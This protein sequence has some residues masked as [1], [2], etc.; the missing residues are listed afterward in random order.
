MQ[1]VKFILCPARHEMGEFWE[2][3]NSVFPSTI[4]DPMDFHELERIASESLKGLQAGDE[5]HLAVTGLTTATLAVVNVCRKLGIRL[6][7]WHYDREGDEY[8]PQRI[9]Y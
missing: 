9:V 6:F 7:C 2:G 3:A 5:L 4:Q 8:V 1:S